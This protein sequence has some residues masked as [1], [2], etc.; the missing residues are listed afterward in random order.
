MQRGAGKA[1]EEKGKEEN[2]ARI[3]TKSFL[4]HLRLFLAYLAFLSACVLS[5]SLL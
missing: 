3:L 4:A 1:R 2:A 5:F